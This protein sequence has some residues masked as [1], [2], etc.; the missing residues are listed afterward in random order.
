MRCDSEHLTSSWILGAPNSC[1]RH[2]RFTAIADR[3][4]TDEFEIIATANTSLIALD[5]DGL[6]AV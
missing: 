4:V 3:K 6:E 2:R 5:L 1:Q